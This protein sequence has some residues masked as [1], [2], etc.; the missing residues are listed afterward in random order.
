MEPILRAEK[1]T[2]RFGE[3]TA[4]REIDIEI[5]AGEI[6][7]IAGENGAGKSTLMKMLYGVY[8]PTAGN[9]Y[10]D[11]EKMERWNPTIAREKG[12]GMVFQ[13]FRLVPA[14]TVLENVFLSLHSAGWKINKK[15]LR[16]EINRI[17]AEYRLSVDPDTEVWKLDLGQR[18]HVEILKI[19]LDPQTRVMIFD[20]PTSV[21]A[22]HE[23]QA[24]LQMLSGFRN[25]GYGIFLITHKIDEI[26]AVSDR[27]TILRQGEH[28]C[29]FER[30]DGF[31]QQQIISAMMGNV[32]VNFELER[33]ECS[34]ENEA[35][36]LQLSLSGVSIKDD[37][38]Q[39]ILHDVSFEMHKAEILGIA[40]ISGNGQRELAEAIYGARKLQSGILS[41][42]EE[43][44]SSTDIAH[45][46]RLGMR[47]V[48]ED[49]IRDNVV[50]T[51]SI[52]ENMA[53]VGLD[54]I[55]RHGDMDWQAMRSQLQTHSEV[56]TLRVPQAERIAGTLSGGNLQKLIVGREFSQN[57]K[58]LV[59]EDP[60][61]GIDVGAIEYIHKQIVAERD[62]GRAVLLVSLEL[63]EVMNLSDRILVIYEGEIVRRQFQP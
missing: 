46:I 45:R 50:P 52:L 55:Y 15:K 39:L 38:D 17:S 20:E 32:P 33:P 10:I 27:I 57:N 53:L 18:Q 16:D 22:P 12:I 30:R 47:M 23:V 44:I 8:Q 42:N 26:L 28:V 59:I 41:A 1:L 56:K 54:P 24:F 5:H 19:L 37:H 60:T 62:K 43:D 31:S 14:F 58:V 63:D 13:D 29:T 25:K 2:K 9:L 61:R 4:N 40:G 21:L 11:G 36:A 6:H 51:F 7:A 49:P 48:T 35:A 3:L 34:E